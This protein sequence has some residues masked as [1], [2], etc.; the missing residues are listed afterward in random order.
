MHHRFA[1]SSENISFV[2]ESVSE[3]SNVSIPCRSQELGQ[4]HGTLW[5]SLHLELHLHSY[6]IQLTQQLK[7]ADI[8]NVVDT[9]N[10]CLNNRWWTAIFRT[11]FSSV[12][13]HI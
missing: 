8:H 6:K 4:S 12:M 3:D 13:K 7:P 1:R 5:R 10:R 9:W 2:S 11:K